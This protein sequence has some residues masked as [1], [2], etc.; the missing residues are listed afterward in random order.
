MYIYMCMHM[1]M[2]VCIRIHIHIYVCTL[3]GPTFAATLHPNFR[4]SRSE[5]GQH[6]FFRYGLNCDH[7]LSHAI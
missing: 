2:Y 1:Y 4:T 7:A 5:K 6:T 3:F